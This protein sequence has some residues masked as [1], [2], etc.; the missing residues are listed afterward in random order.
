MRLHQIPDWSRV[1]ESLSRGSVLKNA[2]RSTLGHF[3][4]LEVEDQGSSHLRLLEVEPDML[5]KILAPL[6]THAGRA[7]EEIAQLEIGG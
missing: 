3:I 1:A 7:I 4:I 2:K 6:K 5:E